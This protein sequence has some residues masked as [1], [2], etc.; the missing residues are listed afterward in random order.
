M[1]PSAELSLPCEAA[2]AR[3][4]R[5]WLRQQVDGSDAGEVA[6]LLLTEV[7]TNAVVH[8]RTGSTVR[9]TQGGGVLCLE[10]ADGSA[11]PPRHVHRGGM[12]EGGRGIDLLDSLS[13]RWGWRPE[14]A[15]KVIWFC[16]AP[17]A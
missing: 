3:T 10:V 12:A 9:L 1:T 11:V 14:A 16:V 4:A 6:E 13:Q 17:A 15:G 2:A 7:V 8:A 5:R